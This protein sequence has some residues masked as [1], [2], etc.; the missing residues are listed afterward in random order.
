MPGTILES[1]CYKVLFFSFSPVGVAATPPKAVSLRDSGIA[2]PT[3][4]IAF[5]TSSNGINDLIPAIA[6]SAE[7]KALATPEALRNAQGNSTR[8]DTGSILG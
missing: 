3:L 1:Y 4:Y 7:I 8:P 6:K 5:T 2:L